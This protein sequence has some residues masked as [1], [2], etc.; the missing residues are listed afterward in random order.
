MIK[1]CKAIIK[2]VETINISLFNFTKDNSVYKQL[3]LRWKMNKDVQCKNQGGIYN[4][5]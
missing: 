2:K 1:K 5:N 3:K 4:D